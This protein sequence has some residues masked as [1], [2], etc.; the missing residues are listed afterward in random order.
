MVYEYF[1]RKPKTMNVFGKGVMGITV[2]YCEKL[3][4]EVKLKGHRKQVG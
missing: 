1:D 3:A 4:V 2:A